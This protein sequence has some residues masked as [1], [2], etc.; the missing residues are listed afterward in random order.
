[1]GIWE[2]Q[3]L[4]YLRKRALRLAES[5]FTWTAR[6]TEIPKQNVLSP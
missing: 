4:P 2:L 6:N 5:I 3:L 1:M